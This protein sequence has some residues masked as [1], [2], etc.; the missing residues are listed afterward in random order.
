MAGGSHFSRGLQISGKNIVV[1]VSLRFTT[2]TARQNRRRGET[3]AANQAPVLLPQSPFSSSQRPPP[4]PLSS[5]LA[6]ALPPPPPQLSSASRA[7]GPRRQDC[8]GCTRRRL[9]RRERRQKRAA[10]PRRLHREAAARQGGGGWPGLGGRTWRRRPG[11]A[12][13]DGRQQAGSKQWMAAS[14]NDGD[15]SE[16]R[17]AAAASKTGLSSAGPHLL[18]S[19]LPG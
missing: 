1:C 16:Q 8:G 6:P 12:A 5:P 4:P 18:S 7:G 3:L 19:P 15:F 10:G 14:V 11:K 17:T 13:S 9:A 2:P